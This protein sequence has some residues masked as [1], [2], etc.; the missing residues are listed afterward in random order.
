MKLYVHEF[1]FRQSQSGTILYNTLVF[2][3]CL[4]MNSWGGER[5]RV[6]RY[7]LSGAKRGK[8]VSW[9]WGGGA[10]RMEEEKYIVCRICSPHF[11][12][13][14]GLYGETTRLWCTEYSCTHPV[15]CKQNRYS[16]PKTLSPSNLIGWYTNNALRIILVTFSIDVSPFALV[17]Y[18]LWW[19][20]GGGGVI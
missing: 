2:L 12:G 6:I 8:W 14:L 7:V 3:T 5:R 19:R 15:A 16:H 18:F 11:L 13:W 20:W 1:G 4:W 17:S 9:G 10:K